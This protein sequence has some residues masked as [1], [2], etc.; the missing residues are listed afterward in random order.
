MDSLKLLL[1]I[2]NNKNLALRTFDIN[3]AFLYADIDEELYITH[4][5]DKRCVTPLKKALYGL[6]QSPKN[7]NDTLREFMNTL[8]LYDSIYSPGLYSSLDGSVMIAAYVDDCIIAAKTDKIIDEYME[9]LRNKFSLKELG[10][11]DNGILDTDILG[12]DLKYDKKMG[13]ITLKME[14]YITKLMNEYEGKIIEDDNKVVIP[15]LRNYD[16]NPKKDKLVITKED[17]KRRVKYLQE[18]IGKLNYIRSRGRIDIEYAVGKLARLAMYPHDNVIKAAMRILQYV[19]NTRNLGLTFTRDE[20]MTKDITITIIT[21]A[22]LATEYDLKSRGGVIIW[23]GNNMIDAFSKKSTIICDSS[24]EAELDALNT[25]EKLGLLLKLKI[26]K[27]NRNNTKLKIRTDLI[28]DSKPA[29]DW[30]KQDYLKPR[31]KFIGIRLE[32]IKERCLDKDIT[33]KKIKGQSN[34]ADPLTKSVT[35][36]QFRVLQQVLEN[37]ITP[38]ILLQLIN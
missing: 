19:Y 15:F 6:K 24:A 9:K 22:S 33:I 14:S 27:L 10:K 29:I 1:I 30:L 18:I 23:I 5:K 8:D 2:A 3:H 21:D 37:E 11:L 25:A 17:Y 26:Q 4:Y 36:K 28:T 35:E 38:Q 7:W 16:I 31:T 12:L 13:K 34:I 20:T 32:R